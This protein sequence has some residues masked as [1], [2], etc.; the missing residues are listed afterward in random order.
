MRTFKKLTAAILAI[1]MV[2][3]SFSMVVG[4]AKEFGMK[5]TIIYDEDAQ[6]IDAVVSA[7]GDNHTA[8]YANVSFDTDALTLLDVNG[9]K[10]KS[11]LA[12][13]E[14]SS[15]VFDVANDSF[16]IL[17]YENNYDDFFMLD[18]GCLSLSYLI[19][20]SGS[21]PEDA[22][23][24]DGDEFFTVHF[25]VEDP[26]AVEELAAS[27]ELVYFGDFPK[28]NYFKD[29]Y[30]GQHTSSKTVKHYLNGKS[31]SATLKYAY[32][33]I[34]VET[35]TTVT[36][37]V[38]DENGDPVKNA[39]VTIDGQTKKTNEDGEVTFT[40]EKGTYSASVSIN[41]YADKSVTVNAGNDNDP[42]HAEIEKLSVPGV[43][44]NLDTTS[45]GTSTVKLKWEAPEDDGNSAITGY[46]ISY[47]KTTSASTS[48][49]KI[50][51]AKTFTKSITGLSDDTTYYFKI[52]AV[53]EI[54][55]GE[56]TDTLKVTTD[57][58]SGGSSGGSTGGSTGGS[59]GGSTPTTPTYIVTYNVGAGTVAGG[60]TK[61]NVLSG[62][63]PSNPPIV[64]APEGKVFKGW[65]TDGKTVKEL[66]TIKIA[67]NTTLRAVY[68][69]KPASGTVTVEK[70]ASYMTGY[71]DGTAKPDKSITR[72]EAATFIARVSADFN[73]SATY[74]GAVF[75]DVPANAW[76]KKYVDFASSKGIIT[77]YTDGTFKPNKEISREEFSTMMVR[78]AG[79]TADNSKSFSDVPETHWAKTNISTLAAKGI[80]TGYTDGTFGLGKKIKR[81][82]AVT[83][84]NRY[85]GR[86]P[87]ATMVKAY[88][89]A[90][91][92]PANDI[93]T[94]WAFAQMVEA[95]VAH[96]ATAF[97]K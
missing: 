7:V 64:T 41:G 35:K 58:E 83:M 2:V 38:T 17:V 66:S 68:A 42:V 39:E 61:E 24:N 93:A 57:E 3:C 94:H 89:D 73:E 19:W 6:T 12:Y 67:G 69:D 27:N 92:Y 32:D 36:I 26:D 23:L 52:A 48:T 86:V 90:N 84:I 34:D 51:N 77:G 44:Q 71:T 9:N 55:T 79:Y 49:V 60:S 76:Y 81:A 78:L 5:M 31:P 28:I 29:V 85:L 37:V 65:S 14:Y 25:K 15:T 21:S 4:A 33:G 96:D 80:I 16:M 95:M 40:V 45:V 62:K 72:A 91:K 82:E 70:H 75:S 56:Y 53:N 88:C 47:G 18:E 13:K 46:V 43:P 22:Y 8:G 30:V 50:T 20:G 11:D 59:A 97:H 63:S 10:V 1:I 87:D 74:T 54:G